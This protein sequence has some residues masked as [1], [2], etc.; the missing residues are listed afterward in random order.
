M[1]FK[2]GADYS[3]KINLNSDEPFK[4]S[5]FDYLVISFAEGLEED[6]VLKLYAD[7]VSKRCSI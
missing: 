6:D 1:Q 2:V 7:G 3:A 4:T 5:D